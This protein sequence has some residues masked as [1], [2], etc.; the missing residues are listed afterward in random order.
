MAGPINS[1][2]LAGASSLACLLLLLLGAPLP[3]L[4]E[5]ERESESELLIL[6]L[7]FGAFLGAITTQ[8]LT[9]HAPGLPYTVVVFIEGLVLAALCDNLDLGH[10]KE[11]VDAWSKIDSELIFFIFLPVLV[12]GEAMSLKWYVAL[13]M[14]MNTSDYFL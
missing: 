3:V 12:F 13:E 7:F 4:A 5:G 6:F 10:L 8:F 9:R 14:N 2:G 11:S 1:M